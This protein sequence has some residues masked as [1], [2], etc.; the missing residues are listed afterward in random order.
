MAHTSEQKLKILY[1][2]DILNEYSDENSVVS[3]GDIITHLKNR[4]INAER[5]SIYDDIALLN[6]VYG[7]K[8]EYKHGKYG[9]YRLICRKF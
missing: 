9:G 6:G 7:C 8:I 4:G 1:L 2:Y 5:K 3:M